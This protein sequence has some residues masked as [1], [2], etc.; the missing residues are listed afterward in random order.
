M[1][2][3]FGFTVVAAQN[4]SAASS[5][6]E[7]YQIDLDIKLIVEILCPKNKTVWILIIH[8]FCYLTSNIVKTIIGS[9][10]YLHLPVVSYQ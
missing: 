3:N 9:K 4:K 8:C 10:L 2:I 1:D 6:D 5:S 7:N